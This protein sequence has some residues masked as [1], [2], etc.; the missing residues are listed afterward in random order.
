MEEA[1]AGYR[2]ARTGP[3]AW[4]VQ[5][6]ICPADRLLELAG[7]LT[8]TM[9]EDEEPWSLVA[10]ARPAD[11]GAIA[12]FVVEMSGGADVEVVETVFPEGGSAAAV[13]GLVEGFGRV[14]YFEVPWRS[15]FTTALD[16]LGAARAQSGRALGA[17][18]RCGGVMAEAFPPPDVLAA[19]LLA[20]RDRHLPI[21]ATAGLHH[22]F[23]HTDAATGFIRHGFINLLAASALAHGGA[24]LAVLTEVLADTDPGDF[25]LEARGL[26]WR[27]RRVDA[28]SLAAIRSDL[29]VG[30][31]SC[32]FD[33]PVTDLA[34]LGMLP[35]A[36]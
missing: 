34:A 5:R 15:S 19:F 33:E 1:V 20:C 21:K 26:T 3:H 23:R 18:V 17:K 25:S 31:G 24:D 36:S 12:D 6:F 30:Y 11:T 9:T 22:P 27:R 14:V 29:F 13:A 2:A 35:V 28:A 8:T 10:T 16:V 4:M 7:V 32:S